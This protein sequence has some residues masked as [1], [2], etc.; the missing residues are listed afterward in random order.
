MHT[1][2][3]Y[4]LIVILTLGFIL[5]RILDYLNSKNWTDK[6]PHELEDVYD[7]EEYK[8]SQHYKKENDR[9]GLITSSFNFILIIAI[10][11]FGGFGWIDGIARQIVTNQILISLVFFGILFFASDII[12]TPFVAYDTYVIEEKY[13]FNKTTFKTFILDKLKSWMLTLIIGGIVLFLIIWFYFQTKEMFWLYTWFASIGFLIFML[14][15][16]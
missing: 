5:E 16:Q 2:I 9:F 6:L 7:I 8:K 10:I 12:N 3:F 11:L 15:F 4:I 13:G 1:N 14:M